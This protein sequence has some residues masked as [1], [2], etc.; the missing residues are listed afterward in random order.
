MTSAS[1][2]FALQE[3]DVQRDARRAI[4]AD[5]ESRLGETDELEEAR[6]SVEDADAVL[7]RLRRRQRE[8]DTQLADLDGKIAPVEKR[9]Y[10]GSVRNPKEL[11][12]LQKDL[13]SQKARRGE[14]EDQGLALLESVEGAARG[15]DEARKALANTEAAWQAD[16]KS[17]QASKAKAEAEY[18]SLDGQRAHFTKSMDPSALGRYEQLRVGKQGR[19]VARVE[20]GICH[21]CRLTLPT[22]LTQRLRT[23]VELVQCPSCDRILVAGQP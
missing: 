2:L 1:D 3:I 7:E 17:L 6:E 14:V 21:G 18:E 19:A 11:T 13:E 9:L 8:L 16:Q 23:G 20:R 15:L 5:I 22:H 4:I 12:D 10:D